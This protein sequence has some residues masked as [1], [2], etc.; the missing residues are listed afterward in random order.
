MLQKYLNN[1]QDKFNWFAI[2]VSSTVKTAEHQKHNS[3]IIIYLFY[4]MFIICLLY[5]YFIKSRLN[6]NFGDFLKYHNVD[7]NNYFFEKL[8][9]QKNNARQQIN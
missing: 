3:F 9:N 1:N 2:A 7:E 4:Y 5:V 8:M 6:R